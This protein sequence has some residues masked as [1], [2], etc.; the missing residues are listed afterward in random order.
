MLESSI[1]VTGTVFGDL[2]QQ[3]ITSHQGMS[4]C[5][6]GE[7]LKVKVYNRLGLPAAQL[8]DRCM[9]VVQ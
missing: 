1:G 8:Q 6:S 2:Y 3:Q 9:A 7:L 4:V 5:L